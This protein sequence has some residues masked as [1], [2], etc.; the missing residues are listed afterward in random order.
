MLVLWHIDKVRESIVWVQEMP[1]P[2]SPFKC[3]LVFQASWSQF[4]FN[5][6]LKIQLIS[7]PLSDKDLCSDFTASTISALPDCLFFLNCSFWNM[8]ALIIIWTIDINTQ[9]AQDKIQVVNL[10]MENSP[11]QGSKKFKL[12]K[13]N[14]VFNKQ[15]IQRFTPVERRVW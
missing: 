15:F 4:W 5:N 9:L 13:R 14:P 2:N 8:K 7:M 1:F 3:R 6:L 11:S 10:S 12:K